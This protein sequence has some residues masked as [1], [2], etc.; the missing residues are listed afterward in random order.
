MVDGIVR[1]APALQLALGLIPKEPRRSPEEKR[2]VVYTKPWVVDLILDLAGYIPDRDLAGTFAVE[3]AAGDGAFLVAMARRLVTSCHRWQRPLSAI[4]NSLLAYELDEESA[5][6][7]RIAVASALRSLGVPSSAAESLASGWVCTGD[8]LMASPCLPAADFVIGNPPYIRLENMDAF[9]AASYRK[10][11]QTMRGRADIY[12]AFY[13]AA[14][15]QLKPNGVCAFIC[16]D[17]W[18]FNQYGAEL[19]RLVT[20]GYAVDSVIEMHRTDAFA[21]DVSAY[22]A[23]TVIRNGQQG[24]VM[25]ARLSQQAALAGEHITTDVFQR[26]QDDG[27]T[28][29]ADVGIQA[30]WVKHWFTGPD[31]WPLVEP[32][33]LALLKELEERFDPLESPQTGTKVGIGV[34]T[35]ADDIFI[36]T[37]PA[38]VEPSRLLP[39]AMAADTTS[40]RLLWSKHYLVNPW[41]PSG[42]VDLDQYPQLAAY[43]GRHRERLLQRHVGRKNPHAWYRTIDRVNYSLLHRPKL[44]IPDIKDQLN[45][46][47]DTGETYPHHNLYYIHSDAWD[48]EVLGGLLMSAIG[49]FFV[50]CY[51]VRMRGGYLRFQA[52]Y[53]RRIRVPRPQDI[54]PAQRAALIHAFRQR[55]RE[56]ATQVALEVYRIPRGSTELVV[57]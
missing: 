17:R 35:G 48:L 53:L 24:P 38:L 55:D 3:P 51:G 8:Y 26:L 46:A 40:G 2:G 1:T 50:E 5:E 4:T 32:A 45:P 31:P 54:S 20:E 9:Q 57:R 15:R 16:A 14:L 11:Y 42:L 28:A 56:L 19:R 34:A 22:P 23:I 7:A 6:R 27:K 29:P 12:I 49:Q 33:R 47:L 13:E 30:T 10:V 36:T 41:S 25:V 39:L 52:Q 21:D 37:D 18:M 43:L 44:Y